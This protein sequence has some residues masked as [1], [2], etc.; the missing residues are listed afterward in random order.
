[1]EIPLKLA[2]MMQTEVVIW[3]ARNVAR[4]S[5]HFESPN[6]QENKPQ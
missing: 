3:N 2:K 4:R 1:M 6:K 5:I